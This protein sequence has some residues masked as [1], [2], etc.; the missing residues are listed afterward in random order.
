MSLLREPNAEP[1]S[2]YRLIEPLGSGGFGEAWKCEAPGGLFKAIKFVYGNLNSLD[3]DSARAEQ[4]KAAL[5]RI[6]KVRHPF[7]LSM[8]RIDV[9]NG[10]LIIVMDL[11]D[12][13]LHDYFEE[14]Q[15]Q[16]LTGIPHHELWGYIRDASEALDHLNEKHHLQHLDIKP[17]NLFLVSGRV[18]VADFGLVKHLERSGSASVLGGVTPLYAAPETFVGKISH[19]SDQYSLA[20]VYTELLTGQRPFKGK[21]PRMLAQQHM[22]EEPELR[23]LPEGERPVVARALAKDPDRRFPTCMHFVRALHQARLPMT[24]QALLREDRDGDRP[25]TLGTMEDLLLEDLPQGL[26][27][28]AEG[29]APKGDALREEVSNLGLTMALPE[30]G[31]IRPTL[32]VG[33]GNMGRRALM[34]LRCRLLDRFGDLDKVPLF[35]FLYIDTDLEAIK[36][37]QRVAAELAFKTHEV[38]HLPLQPVLHY[39]R[40][41]MDQ[42]LDWLPREK[43]YT[44]PRSLNTQGS[45]AL[46]RLAFC[47]NY[48]RLLARLK[49]EIQQAGHPDAL[50]QT[51]SMTGLALRDNVPRA[52]VVGSAS[53]GASGYLADLGYTLRRIFQSLNHDEATV[54]SLLLCGAPDDP[55][56]P[57]VEQANIYATLTELNHFA[58]PT[59]PFSA[60]YSADG[61]RLNNNGPAFDS[62][63]L[64]SFSHRTPEGRH[65]AMAHLG[66]YLF[67]EMTTPLGLRLEKSRQNRV[68]FDCLPFRS[69]GTYSIWF[70][71]GLLLRLAAQKACWR[72]VEEWQA[73]GEPTAQMELDAAQARVLA[74]PE[75]LPETL[76]N[77]LSLA[78]ADHLDG[79]PGEMLT[80]IL[81]SLEEQSQQS[82]AQDD[83]GN[84][85]RTA[86][87]RVQEWLGS[88]LRSS[89]QGTEQRGTGLTTG[90]RKSK[91]NK[92]LE[93]A[94][95]TLAELWEQRLLEAASGLMEIPGRRC[96]VAEAALTR[97]VQYCLDSAAALEQRLHQK[98]ALTQVA[99]VNL[100]RALE[101]C[102]TGAGGFSWFGGRARRLLR[103]FMD[104]LA[105]FARQCLA[106]DLAGAVML[107]YGNLRS[108]LNDRLRD[109][110]FVRQRLRGLQEILE[111]PEQGLP[112]PSE[113]TSGGVE[114]SPG[115]NALVSTESFWES[116]RE[117]TTA[118]VVLPGGLEDLDKAA[119]AF[120]KTMTPDQWQQ[121][122]QSIQDQVLTVQ[123]GLFKA[124]LGSTDFQRHLIPALLSHSITMLGTLLPITDVAEVELSL[125]ETQEGDLTGRIQ[126]YHEQATPVMGASQST[127][128]EALSGSS[129][130]SSPLG[131]GS[132]SRESGRTDNQ[133]SFLLIPGSQAGKKYGEQA[134]G[135][136]DEL[137]IVNVPGQAD[138]MFC[139]EQSYL[140][141]EDLERI[142]NSCR[143]ASEAAV[144]L[145]NS[146]PHSRFDIQD[147]A[148]LDP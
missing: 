145:P 69:L 54:T 114:L 26:G 136:V 129:S 109:L 37:S 39:R 135:Q 113:M 43:L 16:G 30:T 18:K 52:Y 9:V 100:Q 13:S 120:L 126:S 2:G 42:V 4:E 51:V 57:R 117:S 84:W 65:T 72:V 107:F 82:V 55:A 147:W 35:R 131:A 73:I 68:P 38:Y 77:H 83:P 139:R 58:D 76:I 47:D 85:A 134:R 15:S 32:V 40:R 102:I 97:F 41:Q 112:E 70:P 36:Q 89:G 118:R 105:A 92:S 79:A 20:I 44:M 140:R 74:D 61:P 103:L 64:V 115:P 46:G 141:L 86:F 99:E 90:Q 121:L 7:V 10:E 6:K 94:S 110:T 111:A 33:V 88:G 108:R 8:D 21:N 29:P 127:P 144:T 122:D 106:D 17:R 59:I 137:H 23:M 130:R 49:R 34:E 75:L 124:C 80:R 87:G 19:H 56:T 146:S 1:I 119:A 138:L 125:G 98:R 116:I 5:E 104:H 143:A 95:L 27:A 31:A 53:G 132:R 45:R 48:Q 81:A 91:L 11:A 28:G 63:Y 123:G 62:T 22:N 78:A 50:Y 133:I 66:S 128:V 14:C 93:A 3:V 25:R 12:K 96:A 71:R 24:P 60:Q 101:G 148:P 142:M 67:H